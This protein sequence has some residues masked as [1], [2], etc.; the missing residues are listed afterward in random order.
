MAFRRVRSTEH[1]YESILDE[2]SIASFP[3]GTWEV[4]DEAPA[5]VS[6]V[7]RKNDEAETA[8]PSLEDPSYR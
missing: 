3:K 5:P 2:E 4:L 6:A 8:H 1:G 7:S